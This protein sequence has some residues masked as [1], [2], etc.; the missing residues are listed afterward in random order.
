MNEIYAN[1]R[2]TE[3]QRGR[4]FSAP[5]SATLCVLRG[6]KTFNAE[7]AE[8][9]AEDAEKKFLSVPLCLC[10]PLFQAIRPRSRG[11]EVG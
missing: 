4:S 10:G 2:D 7:D 8:E 3:T 6:K 11:A 9:C 5:F 1:H